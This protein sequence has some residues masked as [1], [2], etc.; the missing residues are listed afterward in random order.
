MTACTL[1]SWS[2]HCG[3]SN[4]PEVMHH[5]S[6]FWNLCVTQCVADMKQFKDK[7]MGLIQQ[8]DQHFQLFGELKKDFNVFCSPF[9]VNSSDLSI[10]IQLEIIDLQCDSDLKG[11]F[12]TAGLDTFYQN[13]LP[14]YLNL[15]ALAAK[16]LTMFGSTYLCEQ[17]FSVMRL[18]KPSCAQGSHTATSTTSW[19]WLSQN[20]T[21]AIDVLVKAKRCKVSGV[22]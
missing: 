9:T 21:P 2:C 15:T 1:S 16:L 10:N 4:S 3:T 11:K 7:I 6:F 8:F 12:V 19:S 22:K 5:T 13:L 17:V 14:G 20:V 18:I